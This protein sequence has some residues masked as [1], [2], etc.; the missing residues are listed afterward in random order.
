MTAGRMANAMME[1]DDFKRNSIGVVSTLVLED[2]DR[3]GL[4]I[5]DAKSSTN[6]APQ[7]WRGD[8]L[9]TFLKRSSC[10]ETLRMPS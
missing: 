2:Q 4:V 3:A 6:T 5:N 8:V 10:P 1:T 9:W 7:S